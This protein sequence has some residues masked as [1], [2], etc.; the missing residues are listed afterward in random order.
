MNPAKSGVDRRQMQ[1][2]LYGKMEREPELRELDSIRVNISE[3]KTG[4]SS[5]SSNRAALYTPSIISSMVDDKNHPGLKS[6]WQMPISE[7]L[8]E[9]ET[10]ELPQVL[11]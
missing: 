2:K 9:S 1:S 8:R 3:E 4:T 7:D 6:S 10:S 5:S 11:L